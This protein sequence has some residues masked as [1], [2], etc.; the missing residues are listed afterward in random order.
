MTIK[1]LCKTAHK[2]A[3]EKGFWG[4]DNTGDR[5]C[6][7]GYACDACP[8]NL[9]E[10]RNI[11]ELLMLIVSELG[12]ACEALRNNN[13]ANKE[14][15]QKELKANNLVTTYTTQLKG[16]FEE[17]IADTFIRLADM[18]EALNID[19]EYWINEK[20]KY[21]KTRPKKHGKSF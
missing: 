9:E 17:E 15:Y 2:I 12:E 6:N 11:S 3:V 18:C 19:I 21:N 1:N 14:L 8:S 4:C 5:I 7:D 10:K 20:M 13:K 16:S